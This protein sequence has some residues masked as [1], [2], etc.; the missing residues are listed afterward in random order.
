MTSL[1]RP[2]SGL[3]R[4]HL[5]QRSRHQSVTRAL[6][7][8]DHGAF[9]IAHVEA[10]DYPRLPF[11][12]V[13][14][15]GSETSINSVRLTELLST[16]SFTDRFRLALVIRAVRLMARE[17]W[18]T[19]HQQF[20]ILGASVV[21]APYGVETAHASGDAATAWRH[22]RSRYLWGLLYAL[23]RGVRAAEITFLQVYQAERLRFYDPPKLAAGGTDELRA[24]LASD[25]NDLIQAAHW[26][27]ALAGKLGEVLDTVHSSIVNEGG[28]TVSIAMVGDCVMSETKAF[29]I[30]ALAEN[31]VNSTPQQFWFSAKWG[32]E[33]STDEIEAALEKERYDLLT[34]S[35][36]TIEGL[37]LY[38]SLLK[39]A[40]KSSDTEISAKCEQVLAVIH[41]FVS[42]VRELTDATIVLHGCSGLPLTVARRYLPFLAPL[43][44]CHARVAGLMDNGLQEMASAIGNTL[45]FDETAAVA[46]AGIRRTDRRLFPRVATRFGTM[47][48]PS[49]IGPVFAAEYSDFALAYLTLAR[50]K[51]LLV[52]FDNTLWSGVMGDGAVAH[53]VEAQ[54]LLR[55]LKQ[56]GILLVALSKNDPRN[57]RWEEMELTEKDFVLRKI[58]WNPKPQS[59]A[60]A[61]YQLDLDP[62]SFVMIDDNPVERELVAATL[63]KVQALDPA[64]PKTW[65]WLRMMLSFPNTRQTEEAERRTVMYREAAERRSA[66]SAS[67]DYGQ[68][69]RELDLVL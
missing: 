51:V 22:Y 18:L 10:Q 29:L 23:E 33:L 45:F 34:L 36:L 6:L 44:Q 54:R 20:P 63:P 35:F 38:R 50:A 68:M 64:D 46:A 19:R 67:L 47:Y 16:L 53:D 7:A 41:T 37:P 8:D 14:T 39:T 11:V 65:R 32:K 17:R 55:E 62:A 26:D 56:S 58:N 21:E 43:S 2:G 12:A 60:E 66:M 31:N 9:G 5:P 49:G 25:R 40:P 48:H 69:M 57:I 1:R 3:E 28:R 42:R 59:V 24:M 13:E 61:A 4:D 52:D 30:Q 15:L 27:G